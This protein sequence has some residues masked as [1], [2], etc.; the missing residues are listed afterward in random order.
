MEALLDKVSVPLCVAEFL[1]FWVSSEKSFAL[2]LHKKLCRR[3]M[4]WQSLFTH[5]VNCLPQIIKGS[6]RVGWV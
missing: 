2:K 4:G 3:A 1:A 5:G 6:L